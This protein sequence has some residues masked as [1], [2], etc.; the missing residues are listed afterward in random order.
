MVQHV[1]YKYNILD[2]NTSITKCNINFN[3]LD[4]LSHAV[5]LLFQKDNKLYYITHH[6]SWTIPV[7]VLHSSDLETLED[8]KIAQYTGYYYNYNFEVQ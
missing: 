6:F 8:K 2:D 7:E 5:Q 3:N 1:I 4:K